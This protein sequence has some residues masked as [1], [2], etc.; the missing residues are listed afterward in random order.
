MRMKGKKVLF[1][2][3]DTYSLYSVLNPVIC[4]GLKKFKEVLLNDSVA[5]EWAGVPCVVL[6]KL[7]PEGGD[8]DKYTHSEEQLN[9]GQEEWHSILDKMIYAFEN[10]EP[11]VNDYN[12]DYV[13]GENH[14]KETEDGYF[15][16]NMLPDNDEEYRR[17]RED[18]RSHSE[19]VQE[20]L[21]LFSIYFN[22]LWW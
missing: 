15:E 17:Y 3:N 13:A 7:F 14:M 12:Y 11:D 21:N 8:V 6:N 2:R 20:G 22:N 4:E 16:W 1:S 9:K 19:K 5:K 18:E 10:K